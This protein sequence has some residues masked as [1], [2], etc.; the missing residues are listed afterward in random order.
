VVRDAFLARGHDAV[1]ADLVESEVAGPHIT[2][3]ALT[4][5]HSE[6]WDMMIAFPP[7]QHLSVSGAR[8]FAAKR[9]DGRQQRALQFVRDLMDAPVPKIAIENPVGIISTQIRRPD[10]IIQPYHFGHDASKTTCLWL[11]NLPPLMAT[12]IIVKHRYANQTA[13]GQNKLGPSPTRAMDRARTYQ[14]IAD[15]MAFQWG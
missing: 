14:G 15:A 8:W 6:A 11:T 3:D 12:G 1:S 10:Q 13:S 2:A 7:C 5:A 4:V 9:S